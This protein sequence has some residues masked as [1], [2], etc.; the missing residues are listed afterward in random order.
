VAFS[1]TRGLPNQPVWNTTGDGRSLLCSGGKD[2]GRK[3]RDHLK[4]LLGNGRIT[5]PSRSQH[6]AGRAIFWI[7]N[8]DRYDIVAKARPMQTDDQMK[9]DGWQTLVADTVKLESSITRARSPVYVILGLGRTRFPLPKKLFPRKDCGKKTHRSEFAPAGGGRGPG[10]LRFL[11]LS[12]ATRY[13][14]TYAIE[15]TCSHGRWGRR[16]A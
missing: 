11:P 10:R 12:F 1:K 5:N 4:F 7:G 2:S 9:L 13:T 16:E 8:T 3:V 6:F 14:T 15:P